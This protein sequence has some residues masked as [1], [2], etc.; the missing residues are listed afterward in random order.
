MTVLARP[1][2]DLAEFGFG[3]PEFGFRHFLL[4]RKRSLFRKARDFVLG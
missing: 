1:A 3:V 4:H 2:G